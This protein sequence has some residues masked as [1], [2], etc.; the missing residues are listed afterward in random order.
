MNVCIDVGNTTMAIGFYENKKLLSRII[1]NTDS[2]RTEDEYLLL[3]KDTLKKLEIDPKKV[4]R[5]IYS[6][7]VPSI[8]RPFKGA[9]E[10]FFSMEILTVAP[11]IKTGL[12]LKVD[13]P[14]EIGSD[15]IADLV[16]AKEKYGYP[17]LIVDLGTASKI[18]LLDKSGA[19]SSCLILPGLSLSAN[20]L[21]D[22]AALLPEASLDSPKT[23]LAKNTADAMNAGI[24]FGHIAMIEGL[25]KRYEK[26]I[27]YNCKHIITGGSAIYL[28]DIID[29]SF[30]YDKNLTIDGLEI[31]LEKNEVKYEK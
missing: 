24:I 9:I 21:T 25:I 17:T 29:Q 14:N 18:L 31:I 4:N 19:F 5:I 6:S 12:I 23:V 26:E 11:G 28:K 10:Q 30:V 7:V 8:N 20:S 16:G 15:L 2:K 27:G 1:Q 13:N 22:K 3:L